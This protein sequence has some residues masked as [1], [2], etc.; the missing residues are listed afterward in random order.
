M[1]DTKLSRKYNLQFR[2]IKYQK[3]I[4]TNEF[5]R[6]AVDLLKTTGKNQ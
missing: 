1:V 5:K 2:G 3:K 4:F 6:Q